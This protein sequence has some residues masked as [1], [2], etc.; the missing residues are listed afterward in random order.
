MSNAIL[1]NQRQLF[2]HPLGL[3]VCF[4]TE[5]WE[6]FAF[7]GLKALLFLYLTK[8]HAFNDNNGY[9][10]LG[11]Y[12][13][14]AYALPVVGGLLADQYLG[15]RKA[16]TFGGF[17]MAIGMLGMAYTG[18]AAT[19]EGGADAVAIQI[20]YASLALVAVGVGFLK[21]NI[22]TI[23]GRLYEDNDPRRD[24]AFTVFYMGINLGAFASSLIVGG[25]GEIYGWGYGF[26]LAGIGL[27]TGF[28]VFIKN[29]AHLMGQAESAHPELLEQKVW[30][31]RRETLIYV[32]A[33]VGV[34]VVQQV[35]QTKFDFDAIAHILGMAP[36][37]Q[38]TAT[39]VVAIVLTIAL[40]VWWFKFIFIE[41]SALE[42][43]NMIVL[44]VLIA[45]SAVFWGLYEQ[46]YGT[47]L[48]YSDRVMNIES[49][50]GFK[51]SASQLTSVG[52][53]FIFALA[54]P[55]AWLW[56]FLDR[57]GWNPSASAKFA[58]GL[59]FAGL[60]HFVLQY[61]ALNP[62]ANGLAG[63][64]WFILAYLVLEIGEMALSPIGLSAVTTL[65]VP[66]VVS[67][68]M[69]VWFLASAFGEMIAGRF[70]TLASMEKG[71]AVPDALAIYADVFSTLGWVGVGAA[72]FMFAMTPILNRQIRIAREKTPSV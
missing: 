53:L 24:S 54:I 58:I 15:M 55:F 20:M 3:Y 45:I 49:L 16:V 63:F 48:A 68:M 25:V 47:W 59:L 8:H 18:Q 52:A 12:A 22:S 23:V 44:M 46:T 39:E 10:L 11:T 41:C 43:A 32:L 66:R 71:T 6:R 21:P 29:K 70:G 40:L 62:E 67:L 2:G 7:Y 42:R 17:L 61:A 65:S 50:F 27:L 30:G 38:I 14:L 37:T 1:A 4:F 13:G 69:G 5:M 28:V 31:L 19:P 35:L 33:L 34:V 72:A 60:A 57:K 9:L 64:W 56:P 51:L 36:G 26:A